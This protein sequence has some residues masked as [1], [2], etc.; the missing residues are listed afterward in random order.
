MSKILAVFGATGQQG[1]SI[2]DFV[3]KDSELSAQYRIRAITRDVNSEKAM[4]LKEKV[5][6]VQGDVSD[7]ASLE[8]AFKGVHTIFAM[9]TPSF[10]SDALEAEFNSA[11][12]VAD[13]AISSG[14]DYMI[15]STLPP[16]A[17]ISGGKYTKVTPFDAK[18]KAEQY[19]RSLP[20]KSAFFCAGSFMENFQSQAFIAPRK[21]SDGTWVL[22]RNQS[23]KAKYPLI[24]AIGDS[25]KFVGAIL[26][27]P[28][29]YEGKR[30]C[31]A[32]ALY[33]LEEIVDSLS[34]SAGEI[35]V[36]K[37]I[38]SE[39]FKENLSALGP[40]AD[41]FVEAFRFY[42]TPG[43]FGPDTEELVE[44]AVENARGQPSTLDEFL[45]DHPFR[46]T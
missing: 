7:K 16:V 44:W 41:I 35:I 20:I 17:E 43:Y 21:A 25:G 11:K 28:D 42:E 32:T 2:V 19:I 33:S 13:T 9:T 8:A 36:Y 1:S 37:E 24:D 30:F 3:L 6:V 34:K 31:A 18:A 4:E 14:V 45:R 46:L 5:E 10:G 27:E 29:K 38:T 12:T 39:E 15:F 22:A 23:P 40:L 26:A